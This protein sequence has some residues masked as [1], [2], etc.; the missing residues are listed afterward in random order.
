MNVFRLNIF[1]ST[2]TRILI[3]FQLLS[4]LRLHLHYQI[5]KTLMKSSYTLIAYV[6][7]S[8][9]IHERN[10]RVE[11][12]FFHMK[13]K[14][15]VYYKDHEQIDNVLLNRSVT[16][17]MFISLFPTNNVYEEENSLT[18][19]QFVSKFIY[20]K[21]NRCQKPKKGGYTIGRLT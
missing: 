21:Q 12:L 17:S 11:V 3:E 18:Y 5:N 20:V 8:Y 14:N 13:G 1:T 19:S 6:T 9:S 10:P 15:S 4:F 7:F 2:S 16:K